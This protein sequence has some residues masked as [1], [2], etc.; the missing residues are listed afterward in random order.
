MEHG[1]TVSEH[2]S[3]RAVTRI[4][5]KLMRICPSRP[6]KKPTDAS[7]PSLVADARLPRLFAIAPASF[8]SARLEK[9]QPPDNLTS[10]SSAFPTT[11]TTTASPHR[12]HSHRRDTQWATVIALAAAPATVAAATRRK[13]TSATTALSSTIPTLR[14]NVTT[15]LV[16]RL[17]AHHT[18]HLDRHRPRSK[19][20]LETRTEV[21]S[22]SEALLVDK[23]TDRSRTSHSTRRD[24]E[25]RMALHP[26]MRR[27][28]GPGDSTETMVGHVMEEEDPARRVV[29]VV[30]ALPSSQHTIAPS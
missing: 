23:A 8:F 3:E 24:Q 6:A 21:A 26:T 29:A 12:A 14:H 19:A 9:R 20:T 28:R 10:P 15:I 4:V 13:T 22:L 27:A 17:A 2:L 16:R 30:A 11:P 18:A 1:T 25:H 5:L 7:A